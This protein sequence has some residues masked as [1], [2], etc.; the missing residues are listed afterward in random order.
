[1]SFEING[2]NPTQFRALFDAASEALAARGIQ[3]VVA[4]SDYGYPCRVSL[5]DAAAGD[6]LLLLP[7]EHQPALSPYRASG[8]IFV[9]RSASEAAR[10]VDQVPPYLATRPLSVRAYD[11]E[12][13]MVD[14]NLAKGDAETR[15]L[16][17]E[18]L[19]RDDV[20]YL[21]VH[22]ARRGCFA[23]RVDRPG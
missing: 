5:Q 6:E 11:T 23:C 15:A 4:D 20:A 7:Y 22:F 21:H 18:Y 9:R 16:L 14:A 3:R 8:P 2:L 10:F 17:A 1:V 19:G 13:S 12:G